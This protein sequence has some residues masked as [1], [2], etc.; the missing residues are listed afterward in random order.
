[1]KNKITKK[2]ENENIEH[3]GNDNNVVSKFELEM[4]LIRNINLEKPVYSFNK[5]KL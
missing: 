5:E 1:M 2:E 4:Q 3:R